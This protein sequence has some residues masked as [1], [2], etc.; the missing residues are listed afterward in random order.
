MVLDLSVQELQLLESVVQQ[1]RT[2]PR[3]EICKTDSFAFKENLKQEEQ[4]VEEMLARLGVE[5]GR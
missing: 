4:L 2:D 1:Y 3:Q 5:I